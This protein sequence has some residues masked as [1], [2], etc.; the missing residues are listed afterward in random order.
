METMGSVRRYYLSIYCEG[1]RKTTNVLGYDS[2]RP[3]L[4]SKAARGAY[5][6]RSAKPDTQSFTRSEWHGRGGGGHIMM[7]LKVMG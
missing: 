5:L 1:L 7:G 3:G 2:R 6:I 4:K